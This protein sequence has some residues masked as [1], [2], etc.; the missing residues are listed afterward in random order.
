MGMPKSKVTAKF[1]V[2]IPREVRAK[3]EVR[4]GEILSV[5]AA[6]ADEIILRRYP[7]VK[8]PLES[9]IGRVS[10]GT[11]PIEELEEMMES[12]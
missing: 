4:P 8:N 10:R 2:T 12:R 11:V 5:E 9:L 7:R 1:Q 6:S 3:V